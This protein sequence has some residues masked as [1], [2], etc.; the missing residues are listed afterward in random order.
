MSGRVDSVMWRWVVLGFG[1]LFVAP[2]LAAEESTLT[3]D[4]LRHAAG[5]S[6]GIPQVIAFTW[7]FEPK[8]PYRL[9]ANVG[10]VLILNSLSVRGLLIPR[11]NKFS[12]YAF[13]GGGIIFGTNEDDWDGFSPFGW[14]G[15][16]LRIPIKRVSVFAEIAGIEDSDDFVMSP[17]VAA[18]ILWNY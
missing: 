3:P 12:P 8:A 2:T 15:V 18:G 1:M 14:F 5:V 6:A 4:R 10:G 16:G 13:A 9:Q 7:E 17:N 11:T